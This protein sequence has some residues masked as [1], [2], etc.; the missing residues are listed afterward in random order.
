MSCK[1]LFSGQSGQCRRTRIWRVQWRSA[2]RFLNRPDP[3]PR[4]TPGRPALPCLVSTQSG[5]RVA[6]VA[7]DLYPKQGSRGAQAGTR[8]VGPPRRSVLGISRMRQDVIMRE[9]G[10][11]I[12][13]CGLSG[14]TD[15]ILA[16]ILAYDPRL[17]DRCGGCLGHDHRGWL[18][19]Q[20]SNPRPS[21]SPCPRWF[22][23]GMLSMCIAT[24]VYRS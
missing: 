24:R 5:G 15:D 22:F 20:G 23:L 7:V 1:G 21:H 17:R 3:R 18:L 11:R 6:A 4:P 10:G 2:W 12:G 9:I 14:G 16:E 19:P 13:F 8:G